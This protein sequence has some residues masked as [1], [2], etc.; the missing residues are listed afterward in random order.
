MELIKTSPATKLN[1]MAATA[2]MALGGVAAV[3]MSTGMAFA[4]EA[5]TGLDGAEEAL[6]SALLGL[7][8]NISGVAGPLAA[9]VI[10][11]A[12]IMMLASSVTGNSNAIRIWRGIAIGAAVIF[13]IILI[14]P[15]AMG[16]FQDFGNQINDNKDLSSVLTS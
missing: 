10:V 12:L 9:V 14:V 3:V 15:S 7:F 8:G 4:D 16:W 1:R 13:V 2:G 6:K 5:A 11:F